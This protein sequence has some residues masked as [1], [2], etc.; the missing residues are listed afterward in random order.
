MVLSVSPFG[1][2]PTTIAMPDPS[3]CV[4]G[5]RLLSVRRIKR[6]QAASAGV[7]NRQG[8][9]LGGAYFNDIPATVHPPTAP[10][11]TPSHNPEMHDGL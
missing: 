8:H 1:T 3:P 10:T 11:A 2:A 6:R 7:A 9:N 4:Q 5:G